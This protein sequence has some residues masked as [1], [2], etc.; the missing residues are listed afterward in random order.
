MGTLDGASSFPEIREHEG[1]GTDRGYTEAGTT[2]RR[3]VAVLA[4]GEEGRPREQRCNPRS[5]LNG[6]QIARMSQESPI[7]LGLTGLDLSFI[8]RVYRTSLIVVVIAMLLI[9]ERFGLRAALGWAL[10]STMSLLGIASLEWS[11]RRYIQ[12]GAKSLRPLFLMSI[13]KFLLAAVILAFAFVAALRGW[14]SLLWVLPG[15]MLPHVIIGL[16][17]VG[18]KIVAV[19]RASAQQ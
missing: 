15:F 18:Q 14:L 13:V 2:A 5:L 8:H 4:R 17:F 6:L 12:P 9:W 1:G 11:V 7:N 3:P 19:S 10:G 16:K